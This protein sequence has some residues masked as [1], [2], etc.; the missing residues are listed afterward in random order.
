[1]ICQT[2]LLLFYIYEADSC[3]GLETNKDGKRRAASGDRS[4]MS[5]GWTLGIFMSLPGTPGTMI[6]GNDIT[7]QVIEFYTSHKMQSLSF[8]N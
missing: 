4:A 6:V 3:Y 1:L 5:E 2:G 7:Q 8:N